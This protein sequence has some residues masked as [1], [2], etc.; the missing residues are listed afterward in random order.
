MI[1]DS[2][3]EDLLDQMTLA[4]QQ[5]ALETLGPLSASITAELARLPALD[6]PRA[7]GLRRRARRNDACLLAAARGVRAAI[8]RIAGITGQTSQLSTYGADGRKVLV[9]TA[10]ANHSQRL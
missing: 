1:P 9:G 8:S 4:L 2:A 5:G 6:G 10:L 3:L 7:E